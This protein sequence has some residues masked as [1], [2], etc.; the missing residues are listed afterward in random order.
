MLAES[1]AE[2]AANAGGDLELLGSG[3]SLG[4]R[5]WAGVGHWKFKPTAAGSNSSSGSGAGEAKKKGGRG[6]KEKAAFFIDFFA[7]PVPESAFAPPARAT[8]Q[9]S[10]ASLA[11]ADADPNC[12]LLPEDVHYRAQHLQTLFTKPRVLVRLRLHGKAAGATSAA[13]S[14]SSSS[15]MAGDGL[16]ANGGDG[17]EAAGIPSGTASLLLFNDAPALPNAIMI[18]DDANGAGDVLQYADGSSNDA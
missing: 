10:K 15:A 12:N 16:V 14:S 6:K 2:A 17:G 9:L 11:R 7:E 1:E 5:S 18:A 8:N 3:V 4:L 13:S